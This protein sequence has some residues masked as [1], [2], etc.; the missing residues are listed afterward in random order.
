MDRLTQSRRDERLTMMGHR[1]VMAPRPAIIV[2]ERLETRGDRLITSVYA[3]RVSAEAYASLLVNST[4][5][6]PDP[7]TITA[8][9]QIKGRQLAN[10]TTK[11]KDGNRRS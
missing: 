5:S 4:T 10:A 7:L 2:N 11:Q 3:R 1:E 9:L 6:S 8:R